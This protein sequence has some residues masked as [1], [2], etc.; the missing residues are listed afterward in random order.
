MPRLVEQEVYSMNNFHLSPLEKITELAESVLPDTILAPPPVEVG[1]S[2]RVE[3]SP[4]ALA[5][6]LRISGKLG[7][8]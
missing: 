3:T 5:A 6:E 4:D 2:V 8:G 7:K 1:V